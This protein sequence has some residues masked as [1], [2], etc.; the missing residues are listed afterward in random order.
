MIRI[1]TELDAQFKPF[2]E[3][4]MSELLVSGFSCVFIT[5]AKC[6]KPEGGNQGEYHTRIRLDSPPTVLGINFQ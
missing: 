1:Q 3:I 2:Q 5:N 4:E 6:P